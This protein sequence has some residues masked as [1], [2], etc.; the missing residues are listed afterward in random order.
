MTTEGI[1]AVLPEPQTLT[2]EE[3]AIALRVI[4][5]LR[6]VRYGSLNIQ[7]HDGKVVQLD[8]SQKMR[9]ERPE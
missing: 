1:A 3:M 5:A 9:L 7:I 4:R 6:R 8:V 2:A